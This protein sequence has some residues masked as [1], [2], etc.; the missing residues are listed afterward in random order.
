MCQIPP[1]DHYSLNLF[2]PLD[3]AQSTMLA[4]TDIL[5][6]VALVYLLYASRIGTKRYVCSALARTV[7]NSANSADKL[8]NTLVSKLQLC[9]YANRL[10]DGKMLYTIN[11]G[12]LTRLANTHIIP[13]MH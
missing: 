8:I 12:L 4:S 7:L 5:L 1:H 6:W 10:I 13:C 3:I 11:T 2:K 9:F